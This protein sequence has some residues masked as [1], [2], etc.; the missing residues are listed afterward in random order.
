MAIMYFHFTSIKGPWYGI[1]LILPWKGQ[2]EV[3]L[4][5]GLRDEAQKYF[6]VE[7]FSTLI[8]FMV[9][10]HVFINLRSSLA[11]FLTYSW[12][13]CNFFQHWSKLG[14]FNLQTYGITENY[15]SLCKPCPQHF[16]YKVLRKC[17]T[18]NINIWHVLTFPVQI[19]KKKNWD[20]K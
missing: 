9:P 10:G 4:K 15:S 18:W 8:S 6:S 17:Y 19:L 20:K 7:R 2:L 11:Q 3:T 16:Y 5:L 1:F 13:R 14:N 12:C